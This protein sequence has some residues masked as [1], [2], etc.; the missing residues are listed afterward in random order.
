MTIKQAFDEVNAT[1]EQKKNGL[2]RLLQSDKKRSFI[3]QIKRY[4]AA[5][6]AV[7]VAAGTAG[8]G[9]HFAVINN[10]GGP[11]NVSIGGN[12]AADSIVTPSENTKV[13]S[14]KSGMTFVDDKTFWAQLGKITYRRIDNTP[15]IDTTEINAADDF[16]SLFCTDKQVQSEMLDLF[17]N[18][19]DIT[20]KYIIFSNINE[21][22]GISSDMSAQE[23]EKFKNNSANY[24]TGRT[25]YNDARFYYADKA[26][27]GF[28]TTEEFINAVSQVYTGGNSDKFEEY[29]FE[30]CPDYIQPADKNNTKSKFGINI[31]KEFPIPEL[32]SA[33]TQYC[34]AFYT[35]ESHNSLILLS[36]T[37]KDGA[38]NSKTFELEYISMKYVDGKLRIVVSPYD[39]I[40]LNYT[41]YN[42]YMFNFGI[43]NKAGTDAKTIDI[44]S[45]VGDSDNSSKPEATKAVTTVKTTTSTTAPATSTTPQTT[46]TTTVTTKTTAATTAKP[47]PEP[48]GTATNV[49]LRMTGNAADLDRSML[50]YYKV[51]KAF[52]TNDEIITIKQ[53]KISEVPYFNT[54]GSDHTFDSIDYG[55]YVIAAPMMTTTGDNGFAVFTVTE[56]SSNSII[57]IDLTTGTLP[58][59]KF[60]VV[61]ESIQEEDTLPDYSEQQYA[62]AEKSYTYEEHTYI[63]VE[64]IHYG[65]TYIDD[66]IWQGARLIDTVDGRRITGCKVKKTPVSYASISVDGKIITGEEVNDY[67]LLVSIDNIQGE[68][69]HI[70]STIM[71]RKDLV[72]SS[73]PKVILGDR[74]YSSYIATDYGDIDIDMV[75]KDDNGKPVKNCEIYFVHLDDIDTYNLEHNN[76]N[77]HASGDYCIANTDSEGR[78]ST[79]TALCCGKNYLSVSNAVEKGYVFNNDRY[80]DIIPKDPVPQL[81][82]EIPITNE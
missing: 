16:D 62:L 30:Y 59:D 66:N 36:L 69:N 49:T 38:D 75:L 55:I 53:S 77:V 50:Y 4:A 61:D 18:A 43:E 31:D 58:A 9:I 20:N 52:L 35:D 82:A 48:T 51:D 40:F 22:V 56:S 65:D 45:V 63:P 23:I 12:S 72:K 6:A 32:Y 74:F 17:D 44:T 25:S 29:F 7:V 57:N 21:A 47:A 11:I 8:V 5:A 1:D 37:A 34:T 67:I 68:N 10:Q 28:D 42:N 78:V 54:D 73:K 19:I 80:Y 33:H 13:H 81:I 71:V 70:Y 39:Y 24:F 79:F 2:D 60:E 76:A 27:F 64:L 41:Y 3:P 15:T 46:A 14:E 26:Y